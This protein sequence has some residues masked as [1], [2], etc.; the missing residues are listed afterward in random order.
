MQL[1]TIKPSLCIFESQRIYNLFENNHENFALHLISDIEKSM[2]ETSC[3]SKVDANNEILWNNDFLLTSS[4]GST[5]QPKPIIFSQK[6]KLM[7]AKS[8]ITIWDL[9]YTSIIINASPFII[10][11]AKTHLFSCQSTLITMRKFISA[12]G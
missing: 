8:A 12:T 9:D 1:N 11:R 6:T 7:R 5:G 10:L 2:S 3:P 4:S